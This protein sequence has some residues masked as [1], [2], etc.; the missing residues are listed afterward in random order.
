VR[1][2]ESDEAPSQLAEYFEELHY[3]PPDGSVVDVCLELN[4]WVPAL[5]KRLERGVAL[6]IDYA[7]SPPRDSLLTYYRHSMGSDPLVRLGQQD[8]SA[9][10]D[11]RTL[12]RLAVAEGLRAGAI[13]QRGL[14]LNLG[15][16]QVY[17]K[18][19]GQTDREALAH[20]IDPKGAGGQITAVFLVRGMDADNKPAGAVGR[21]WPEPDK[22]PSLPPDP[23]E[24]DFLDQWRE[25]FPALGRSVE[26]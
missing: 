22:V 13:A 12:M 5:A 1:F 17:G 9:H 19:G 6:V 11:L 2:V 23:D 8:I 15:F 24:A 25:A 14:L 4:E 20:L 18:L 7:A 21:E 16:G 3:A 10:V 26:P